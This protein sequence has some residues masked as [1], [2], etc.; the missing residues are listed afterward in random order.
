MNSE[1]RVIFLYGENNHVN[2]KADEFH[3]DEGF[4][5]AYVHNELVA[6]FRLDYINGAYISEKGMTSK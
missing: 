4:L 6:I 2:V 5:K 3:E 1:Q